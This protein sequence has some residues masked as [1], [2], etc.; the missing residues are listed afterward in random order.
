MLKKLLVASLLMNSLSPLIVTADDTTSQTVINAENVSLSNVSNVVINSQN[1]TV[2]LEETTVNGTVV[3]SRNN[4]N[5]QIKFTPKLSEIPDFMNRVVKESSGK[6]AFAWGGEYDLN[7]KTR[8]NIGTN[9]REYEVLG[10]DI[11]LTSE[12]YDM[13]TDYYSYTEMKDGAI[14]TKDIITAL[15]KASRIVAMSFCE[16]RSCRL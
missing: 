5:P 13:N 16:P 9:S 4:E 14:S 8:E 2:T 10:S 6:L 11:L 12:K 7:R 3:R 1:T 15:Y